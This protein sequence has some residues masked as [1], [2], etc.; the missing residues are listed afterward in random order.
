MT[1]IRLMEPAPPPAPA[2]IAPARIT[3]RPSRHIT[4]RRA[5]HFGIHMPPPSL[6]DKMVE[7]ETTRKR[8][9]AQTEIENSSTNLVKCAVG[10][11]ARDEKHS[12]KFRAEIDASEAIPELLRNHLSFV[13]NLPSSVQLLGLIGEKFVRTFFE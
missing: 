3:P 12:K 8:L 1:E 2:R 10:K 13:G 7:K 9:L 5:N 4:G 11:M 6:A